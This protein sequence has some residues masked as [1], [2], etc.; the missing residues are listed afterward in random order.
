MAVAAGHRAEVLA[1]H[2]LEA[3]GLRLLLRNAHARGG[4]LDLVMRHG[5]TLVVVEVRQRRSSRFG[6]A[7]E[8]VDW[9]KQA[10]IV[11][12]T[13]LLLAQ[14]PEWAHMPVRFDVVAIDGGGRIDWL[15]NAFDAGDG[16]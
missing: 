2:W 13:R 6:S 7:L 9:R 8:S 11:R 14:R 15:Q 10:R 16:R 3:R 4:E 1:R 12:A 5:K